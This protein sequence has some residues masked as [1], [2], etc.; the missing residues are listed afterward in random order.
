MTFFRIDRSMAPSQRLLVV[1]APVALAFAA[2]AAPVEAQGPRQCLLNYES[3]TG[4]TRTTAIE[5]PS[6]KYN[7]FQGG[8]ITYHCQGQDNTITADSSEYY[9]DQSVLYLI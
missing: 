3:P 9:G 7:V 8:G 4:N 1:I 2:A 6:K 5:L